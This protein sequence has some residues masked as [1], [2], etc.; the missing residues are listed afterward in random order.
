MK[1]FTKSMEPGTGLGVAERLSY[2]SGNVGIALINTIVATFLMFFYTDVMMLNA[3][4]IG[5]ILLVSRVFDG[6]TDIIMGMIVDRTQS[7][8]GK[9]RVWVLR[10]CIPYAVSGFFLVCVPGGATELIQYVYVFLTYNLCNSIFL[11]ALYVPYNA[12]TCNITSNP[13]ERGILGVFVIFGATVGTMIV[14]STVDAATKAL[15][16]DQRAWQIVIFIY[17]LCGVILHLL[18]F[19]GTKERCISSNTGEKI[20]VKEEMRA[21]FNNKYWIMAVFSVLLVMFFTT[22]TGSAGIYYAKGVLG[23]TAHYATLANAMLIVQIIS[24]CIAFIPMKK[25]GKRNTLLLGLL[26]LIGGLAIQCLFASNLQMLIFSNALKGLGGGFAGGVAYGLIADTVDYGQWKTGI[27]A[28]GVGMASL[29]F[30]TK[31]AGGL[32]GAIVGWVNQLFGYVPT[33]AVQ[34]KSA[35]F[36]LNMCYGYLP[37]IFCAAAFIVMLR[38]DLDKIYPQIQADLQ[39]RNEEKK[40]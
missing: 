6:I 14:Q 17:A 3:G 16:G 23:D 18:C 13:Y 40:S 8:H 36:G 1:I 20:H 2:M 29:T 34:S 5:S 26:I 39:K 31:I 11:T 22:F 15:G 25:W 32:S 27:K 4:I 30:V 19:W 10:M 33:A 38:Y 35:V 24:L 21:L 28:E 9:A 37:F 7:K 12:M